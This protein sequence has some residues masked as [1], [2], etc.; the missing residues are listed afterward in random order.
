MRENMLRFLHMKNPWKKRVH[1]CAAPQRNPRG[2]R[3]DQFFY[4]NRMF[5]ELREDVH[6]ADGRWF[7]RGAAEGRVGSDRNACYSGRVCKYLMRFRAV[8]PGRT[9]VVT[10]VGLVFS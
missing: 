6:G 5:P 4:W 8:R 2:D 10:R 9:E 7:R 3:D 1:V